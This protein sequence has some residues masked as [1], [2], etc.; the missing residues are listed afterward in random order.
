MLFNYVTASGDTAILKRALPLAEVGFRLPILYPLSLRSAKACPRQT[1]LQWWRDNRTIS[2][3]SPYTNV[4]HAVA[5]YSV[6]IN[7]A[8]RPEVRFTS[9]SIIL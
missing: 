1:E 8:P 5:H 7:T 4:T 2:I 3:K 9:T 6:D